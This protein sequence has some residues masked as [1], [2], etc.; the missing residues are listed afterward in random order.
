MINKIPTTAYVYNSRLEEESIKEYL[1]TQSPPLQAPWHFHFI[2]SLIFETIKLEVLVL[3][4]DY[5]YPGKNMQIFILIL[6][7]KR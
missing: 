6:W 7:K 5:T 1:Q 3:L 2:K 4:H